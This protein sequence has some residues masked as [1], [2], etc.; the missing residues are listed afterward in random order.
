ML[1]G[2]LRRAG[3]SAYMVRSHTLVT[4]FFRYSQDVWLLGLLGAL[5]KRDYSPGLVRSCELVIVVIGALRANGYSRILVLSEVVVTP[6][7]WRSHLGWL[8][9]L[10]GTLK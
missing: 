8:L 6:T 4:L 2:T 1:P 10:I 3:Y 5:T 7:A 9:S